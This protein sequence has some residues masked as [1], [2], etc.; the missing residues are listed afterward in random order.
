MNEN[1]NEEALLFRDFKSG[2][3]ESL[4][5]ALDEPSPENYYRFI[6][7]LTGARFLALRSDGDGL[8]LVPNPEDADTGYIPLF[9]SLGQVDLVR[10]APNMHVGVLT[11]SGV[12]KMLLSN[13]VICGIILNPGGRPL[14]LPSGKLFEA[15]RNYFMADRKVREESRWKRYIN[16]SP[17]DP[18]RMFSRAD[19]PVWL[20]AYLMAFTAGHPEVDK[21]YVVNTSTGGGAATGEHLLVALEF[22]DAGEGLFPDLAVG[23]QS[24]R[25]GG[26]VEFV[27]VDASLKRTLANMGV[28]PVWENNRQVYH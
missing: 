11:Y 13:K 10:R 16:E 23:I 15:T 3:E 12:C 27:K 6:H 4:P 22:D 17:A 14:I 25:A 21:A 9:T 8:P 26:F 24:L 2:L 19:C 7:D 5:L 28:G 20:E 1:R 18:E